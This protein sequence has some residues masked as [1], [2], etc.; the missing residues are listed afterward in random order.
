MAISVKKG[1]RERR[2][3]KRSDARSVGL[4]SVIIGGGAAVVIADRERCEA[5]QGSAVQYPLSTNL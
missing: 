3:V 5:K 2:R 1:E 4:G